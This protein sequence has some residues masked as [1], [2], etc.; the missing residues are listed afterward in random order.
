MR[1]ACVFY[2]HKVMLCSDL[3][4]PVHIYRH[5]KDMDRNDGLCPG[6]YL[7]PYEFRVNLERLPVNIGEHR[8]RS[9]QKNRL[10]SCH[11][12]IRGYNYLVSDTDS[13]LV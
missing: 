6:R 3:H 10:Y 8:D 2:Y 9:I 13:G 5:S 12:S 1:L 7:F 4:D 11:E